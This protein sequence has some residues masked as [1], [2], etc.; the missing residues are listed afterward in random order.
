MFDLR[1]VCHRHRPAM[2]GWFGHGAGAC[3]GRRGH[4][5][6]ASHQVKCEAL[7]EPYGLGAKTPS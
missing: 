1:G 2:A 4:R 7:S 6:D 5:R 3:V